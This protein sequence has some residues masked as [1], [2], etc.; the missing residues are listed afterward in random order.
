MCTYVCTY[1]VYL[2]DSYCG[3]RCMHVLTY[4]LSVLIR[5]LLWYADM[6][7][8]VLIILYLFIDLFRCAGKSLSPLACVTIRLEN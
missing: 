4:L 2:S 5:F 7:I 6:L 3:M 8:A 1:L